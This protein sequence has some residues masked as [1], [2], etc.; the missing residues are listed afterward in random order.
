[1]KKLLFTVLAVCMFSLLSWADQGLLK[2]GHPEEYTVKKGDTLWDISNTFLN[3]PWK[4]PEIWHVNPQIENPHLIYPG[5]VI[6]LI[7]VDGTPRLTLERTVKLAPGDS[8]LSPSVRVLPNDEAITAIPLDRI[9][10]FLSRSRIVAPGE[11]EAAP[12]ILAGAEKRLVTGAGDR[13]YVKGNLEE[14]SNYGVFRKGDI[15]RDPITKE[16]LGVHALSVGMVG[17]RSQQDDIAT[18][19][20]VRTSE[21]IRLGDRLL[22]SEDRAVD[23][24]FYPNAPEND[25]DGLILAVEGGV[26]QIGKMNVVILNRG[27]R[28]GLAVGNV[29]AI[30]K[31]GELVRDRVTGKNVQL[32]DERAGLLMV[33]RTFEKM[34]FGL[35]LEADRPLSTNDKI[36]NP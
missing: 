25:V 5:D 24:T 31:Q 2:S 34:S 30:Y 32:P 27:D 12:Y 23:S 28:E 17:V 20:V 6:R 22:R 13:A 35:V 4:W 10:S 29:L 9:D 7:Y 15:L 3:T 18:V 21:E 1:M 26:T 16:V 36:R 14:E 8:K 11:L 33:F 19:T